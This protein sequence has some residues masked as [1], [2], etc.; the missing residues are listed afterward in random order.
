MRGHNR[1]SRPRNRRRPTDTR[2]HGTARISADLRPAGGGSNHTLRELLAAAARAISMRA[3]VVGGVPCAGLVTGRSP[4]TI[5][6][7]TTRKPSGRIGVPQRAGPFDPRRSETYPMPPL[8]VKS[9]RAAGARVLG[10]SDI[11]HN[12]AD[13]DQLAAVQRP[14]R[15]PALRFLSGLHGEFRANRRRW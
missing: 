13:G 11:T 8:P 5:S 9:S 4:T 7:L 3:S 6:S 10:R 1:T 2:R 14:A 12:L 15:L